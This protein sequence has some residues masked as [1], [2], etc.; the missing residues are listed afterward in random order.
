[1]ATQ[2]Y[3]RKCKQCGKVWHSLVSRE[4]QVKNSIKSSQC[5]KSVAACGMCSGNWL[6]FGP[7]TQAERNIEASQ[8]ELD[9]L[10]KC[11]KCGS[12]NYKEEI[13]TYEEK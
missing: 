7:A 11:P 12:M 1:M 3:K 4:E 2:E 5:H 10:R 8:S 13:I 9:R 6:A